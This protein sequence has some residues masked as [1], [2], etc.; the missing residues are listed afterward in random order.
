[1]YKLVKIQTSPQAKQPQKVLVIY[2]GGT[3]GMVYDHK[4]GSLVPFDFKLI[5]ENLPEIQRL[6]FEITI[7]SMDQ[8]I[9][10]ANVSPAYWQKLVAIIEKY[11]DRFGAFV[12]LHGTDTMAYTASAMS[13]MIQNLHKPII[14]TGAQLPIGAAR[15]DAKENFITALELATATKDGQSILNEV[16]IYFNN[17][18]LRANRSRKH[19]SQ[20]FDAFVSENYPALAT[21][22][23]DIEYN[24]PYLWPKKAE[25]S[26]IF[27]TE[28]NASVAFL[29]LFPGLGAPYLEAVLSTPGLKAVVLEAYGSGTAPTDSWFL[30]AIQQAIY[31]GI[32]VV[33]V[34]QCIG[35]KVVEGKY[36]TSLA[37]YQLG[38]VSAGD[39]SAEAAISKLMY[40][41]G[42]NLSYTASCALFRKNLAGELSEF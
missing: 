38:V 42:Q 41:L 35:G 2:T 22:G 17:S 30:E 24:W 9:D 18:L 12:I 40:I 36:A 28:L 5:P 37:L 27:T 34:S 26:T 39:M 10:S 13:F 31:K 33:S 15:T 20:H 16:C 3:L 25:G 4:L 23:I 11:Y 14:F 6:N 29:K 7:L 1:M 21:V 19:E 8:L 32:M